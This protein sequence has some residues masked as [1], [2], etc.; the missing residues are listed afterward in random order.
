MDNPAGVLGCRSWVEH[1]PS[2]D[3]P[4]D[5]LSRDGRADPHVAA[6]VLSGEWT[7]HEPVVP[8]AFAALCFDDLWGW[9]LEF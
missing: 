4:A 6:S 1:I 9:G 7:Y 3:N 5:V 8:T 2:K